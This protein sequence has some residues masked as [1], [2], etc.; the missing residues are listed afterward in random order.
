MRRRHLFPGLIGLTA[1]SET[2]IL[3]GFVYESQNP[4]HRIRDR[5]TYRPAA[6]TRRA[7][8]VIIGGGMAG[9]S[10]G[11]W[12]RRQGFHDFLI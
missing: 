12:L 1:K 2:N 3:G 5:A 10:A 9:L 11:W 7:K 8:I 4:G 6:G